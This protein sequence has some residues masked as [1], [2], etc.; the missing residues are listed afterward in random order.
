MRPHHRRRGRGDQTLPLARIPRGTD[1]VG[2]DPPDTAGP[3][4]GLSRL[5]R[6]AAACNSC[7]RREWRV[8]ADARDSSAATPPLSDTAAECPRRRRCRGLTIGSQWTRATPHRNESASPVAWGEGT[9]AGT[10]N[11]DGAGIDWVA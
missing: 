10:W 6:P 11:E 7:R 9:A 5:S 8:R 1:G 2:G 4:I 3:A